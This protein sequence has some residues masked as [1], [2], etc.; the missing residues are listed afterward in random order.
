MFGLFRVCLGFV[1]SC[2]ALFGVVWRC[3]EFYGV[4]LELGGVAGVG[5]WC[6]LPLRLVDVC[7]WLLMFAGACSM[8]PYV[9]LRV[10]CFLLVVQ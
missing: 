10:G 6:A 3:V 4:V 9:L 7:S 8:C 5:C 2:V 1:W